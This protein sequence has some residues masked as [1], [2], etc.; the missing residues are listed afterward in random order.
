MD[1][2]SISWSSRL[3][4]AL[5]LIHYN[6]LFLSS[7]GISCRFFLR[8]Q[9]FYKYSELGYQII[10]LNIALNQPSIFEPILSTKCFLKVLS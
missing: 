4:K 2:R 10:P 3:L 1:E 7:C 5:V 8:D 6:E 9:K